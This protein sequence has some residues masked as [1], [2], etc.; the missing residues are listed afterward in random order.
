MQ[1]CT[2]LRSQIRELFAAWPMIGSIQGAMRTRRLL[3]GPAL[4]LLS[5]AGFF[6]CYVAATS[7]S[8]ARMTVIEQ[9]FAARTRRM[10]R[11][12]HLPRRSMVDQP[13]QMRAGRLHAERT[14]PAAASSNRKC[15]SCSLTVIS[16]AKASFSI[17]EWM[18]RS[19]N[20]IGDRKR[21]RRPRSD[22]E[23]TREVAELT[24][25]CPCLQQPVDFCAASRCQVTRFSLRRLWIWC[26]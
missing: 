23:A 6:V 7:R 12:V 1:G 16:L 5:R 20:S 2:V 15:V 3:I 14:R 11:A 21:L 25:R 26:G 24:R 17:V 19:P 10:E 18:E 13:D 8:R 9:A 4:L 22:R